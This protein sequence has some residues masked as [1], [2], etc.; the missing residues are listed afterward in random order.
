MATS[1][2]ACT[3]PYRCLDPV[4]N[5]NVIVELQPTPLPDS[6]LRTFVFADIAPT[7]GT[8]DIGDPG[9]AGFVG[10]IND[11]LGEVQTDVYGNPLCTLYEGEDPV[12]HVID[13]GF[14]DADMLP[15]PIPG[16]GGNC[17]SDAN[18]DLAIPHLGTNRYTLTVIPPDGQTWIQTT[19]LEGNH[20]WD[21]WIMEGA[22]GFDTEFV[23]GRRT[24]SRNPFLVLLHR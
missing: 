9:L 4:A 14:L 22:T 19:T 16:T 6:T 17:V 3:L 7:N 21:T 24:R 2:T 10:H 18:G 15:V 11:Y 20:D 8:P 5:A 23:V 13:P 12:T 1:W